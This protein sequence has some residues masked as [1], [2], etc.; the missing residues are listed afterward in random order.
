M[1]TSYE[2]LSALLK[3][4]FHDELPTMVVQV[5]WSDILDFIHRRFVMYRRYKTQHQQWDVCGRNL[6]QYSIELQHS[7]SEFIESM[8]KMIVA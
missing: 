7:R 3:E 4:L 8:I 1:P 6:F 2:K 5:T